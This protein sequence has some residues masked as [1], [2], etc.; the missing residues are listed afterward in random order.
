VIRL[1]VIELFSELH[2]CFWS[3]NC[4]MAG[5]SKYTA[6]VSSLPLVKT[7]AF[8]ATLKLTSIG[9][10]VQLGKDNFSIL[11][12]LINH[13]GR[14]LPYDTKIPEDVRIFV[15]IVVAV[16]CLHYQIN[17]ILAISNRFQNSFELVIS[18]SESDIQYYRD[19]FLHW[20][21]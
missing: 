5:A 19:Q 6:A 1:A 9:E 15:P 20:S 3:Q 10:Y 7:G 21:V 16:A 18:L 4:V 11:A 8:R 2:Q 14:L 13:D 12:L 17:G